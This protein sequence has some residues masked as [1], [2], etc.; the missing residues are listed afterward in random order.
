MNLAR[1][2]HFRHGKGAAKERRGDAETRRLGDS[3]RRR[4]EGAKPFLKLVLL[5]PAM[6]VLG[7]ALA[8]YADSPW[9]VVPFFGALTL[10]SFAALNYALYI[11]VAFLPFSFRFIMLSG[12]EMQVPTEPLLGIMA[13]ATILRWVVI[14]RGE[15]KTRGRKDAGTRIG[16]T[17]TRRQSPRRRVAASPRPRSRPGAVSQKFPFRFPIALYGVSLYLSMINAGHLYSAAKGSLR[18]VAYMMLAV[19]V[20]NV[21][22]DKQRLKWLFVMSIVPATVAVGWTVIFLADRLEIWRWS[23]AYEDLPF[24]SYSHYGAFAAVILLIL[25][26]RFIFDKGVYDR[27]IW[28]ILLG[29]YGVAICF[30]FSRGVWVS[31]I[32]ATG[33]LLL[34]KAGGIQH[35]RILIIGGAVVSFAILLCVPRLSGLIVMRAKTI[36]SFGYGANKERLFRWGAALMMFLRHPVIGCGYGSFAFSYVNDPAIIGT[37]LSQFGMGAHSE[38]L[39]ILAETGL[40]GFFAWMWIIIS[41]FLYGFHLLKRLDL[42]QE[43]H[44]SFYRSLVIGI[45]AAE[46]SL[47]IHFFVNNLIQSDIVGV[48]FWL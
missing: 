6:I 42:A 43:T 12:T 31:L 48:P 27:V 33:F 36:T 19:V 38:Y 45:M 10:T 35:K 22:T 18:A 16:D 37:Y 28:T 32:A 17:E 21:I 4:I 7:S 24:T 3:P 14:G 46:A 1:I 39:Q 11:L 34:Q 9:L 29:F 47:L 8:L 23:S 40:I 44:S 2:S 5:F 13:I 26:A 15:E 25:L 20:F 30:S 41:F